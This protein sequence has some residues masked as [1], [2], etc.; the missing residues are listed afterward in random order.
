MWSRDGKDVGH[1]TC[2]ARSGRVVG[3][4]IEQAKAAFDHQASTI[5]LSNNA[6]IRIKES[7][8]SHIVRGV[9]VVCNGSSGCSRQNGKEDEK[10]ERIHNEAFVFE[11]WWFEGRSFVIWALIMEKPTLKPISS[12]WTGIY[13]FGWWSV[14]SLWLAM[15]HTDLPRTALGLCSKH[16]FPSCVI[17][18]TLRLKRLVQSVPSTKWTFS[19]ILLPRNS[20]NLW[21]E[22]TR[23]GFMVIWLNRDS[24]TIL[25]SKGISWRVFSI[26]LPIV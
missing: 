16:V 1:V 4:W 25:Q 13:T 2:T 26:R 22:M 15:F 5:W 21:Q 8:I 24:L 19:L 17:L 10:E 9:L 14:F 6:W 3:Y 12:N 20:P 23:Q 11:W 18:G 7:V